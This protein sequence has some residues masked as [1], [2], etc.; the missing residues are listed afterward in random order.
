MSLAAEDRLDRIVAGGDLSGAFFFYGDAERQRD[1]AARRLAEAALDPATRD[2]NLDVF[3]SADVTPESIAA[4]L[5]MPPVMSARRVVLLFD[6]ERLTPTGCSVIEDVLG[7][8]PGDV[9]LIVTATIPAK[10]KKAFYRRLR[11]GAVCL[12]WTAPREAEIPG[13]IMERAER[14][15]G[16]A[17]S[18]DA[19]AAL[20]TAVGA[21]LGVLE[22]ELEKLAAS[23]GDSEI[24][25]ERV[26]ALVPNVREVNRWSWLDA[27]AGREYLAARRD[28]PALL[29]APGESAVGLLVGLVDNHL[30]LGIAR[31]AG[32][33]GVNAALG[34]AGK[35]YL[36]FKAR[37]WTRQAR[38]WT[39]GEIES[40]LDLLLEADRQAKSGHGD[41]AVLDGLLLRLEAL[42]REER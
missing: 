40:A 3:R 18:E 2:F 30:Y 26:R 41:V 27:V 22:V 8:I 15:H 12:E 5:A 6:A 29:A 38:R 36:K 13:W 10:S 24:D 35:P 34:R 23:A 42:R 21:D 16:V 32:A 39:A 28:L 33:D 19:A 9:T 7:R 37:T 1:E 11:D 4:A 14:R 25:L 17:I 20:A 31:E